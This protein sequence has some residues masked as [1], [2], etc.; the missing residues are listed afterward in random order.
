MSSGRFC[1]VSRSIVGSSLCISQ[2]GC[3]SGRSR[4]V[5]R[6]V[7]GSL[8]EVVVSPGPRKVPEGLRKRVRKVVCVLFGLLLPMQ[9]SS[10]SVLSRFTQ[11]LLPIL[12][13]YT[14]PLIFVEGVDSDISDMILY[15]CRVGN[16]YTG[17]DA[18]V[19]KLGGARCSIIY[20]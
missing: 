2:F 19:V 3:S 6:R 18:L 11:I 17:R 15:I 7:A 13:T 9:T 14:S 1:K 12:S 10:T 4:K 20:F 16:I 5:S 8:F